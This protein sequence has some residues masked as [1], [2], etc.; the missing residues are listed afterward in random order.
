MWIIVTVILVFFLGIF[1]VPLTLVI[2]S[3]QD[4]YSL[5]LTGYLKFRWIRSET[6]SWLLIRLLGIPVRISS[7]D[8]FTP[9]RSRKE[10]KKRPVKKRGP[11]PFRRIFSKIRSAVTFQKLYANIDTGDFPLNAQLIPIAGYLQQYKYEVSVNFQNVNEVN[12]RATTYLFRLMWI[13]I[14]IFLFT[15]I[16]NHGK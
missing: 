5:H 3:R 1:V 6:G 8:K 12:I 7:F 13:V 4:I 15:K 16:K 14:N 9:G 2:D 10:K 11:I